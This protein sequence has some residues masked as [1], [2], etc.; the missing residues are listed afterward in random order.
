MVN[1]TKFGSVDSPAANPKPRT[2]MPQERLHRTQAPIPKNFREVNP[3]GIGGA[4]DTEMKGARS[5][6]NLDLG[7]REG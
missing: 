4:M 2:N 3:L 6:G 1:Q 5:K 7:T